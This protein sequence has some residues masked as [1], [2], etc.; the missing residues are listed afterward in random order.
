[1]AVQLSV[2]CFVD[3]YVD[4]ASVCMWPLLPWSFIA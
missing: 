3:V 1:M 4:A 2:P